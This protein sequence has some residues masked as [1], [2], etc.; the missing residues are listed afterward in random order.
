M[1]KKEVYEHLA[2]I[3]LDTSSKKKK[4]IKEPLRFKYLLFVS[5]ALTL[6]FTTGLSGFFFKSKRVNP[7]VELVLQH[8]V[9]KLDF[10]FDP[11]KKEIYAI[12]LKKMDLNRFKALNFAL[13]KRDYQD[14]VAVK[15]EFIN[16]FN[17]KSELYLK[18]ISH[19]WQEYKIRLCDFKGIS[20]WSAMTD[21]SFT[22]EEWNTTEK[23]GAVYVD[24][25]RFLR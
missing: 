2:R 6:S 12:K 10:N 21:L 22:V 8:D 15:V 14:N 7:Q 17:E 1:D 18:N 9:S 20:N 16:T 3:Y 11:A 25:I 23:K 24:N 5:L 19:R 4:R 13:K